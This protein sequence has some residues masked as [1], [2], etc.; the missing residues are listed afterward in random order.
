MGPR[1]S[2]A[3]T[4]VCHRSYIIAVSFP[5]Q[6]NWMPQHS[7]NIAE[8][9][10]KHH[11]P[12]QTVSY[13]RSGTREASLSIWLKDTGIYFTPLLI[14]KITRLQ[15]KCIF[16]FLQ[17]RSTTY[18]SLKFD[19]LIVSLIKFFFFTSFKTSLSRN[20]FILHRCQSLAGHIT[21]TYWCLSELND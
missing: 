13:R 5:H 8:S 12:N 10:V 9:G 16:Y 4:Q 7:W 17:N 1:C 14:L 3:E 18:I 2:S 6:Y 19:H 11:K 21:C 15:N 20:K